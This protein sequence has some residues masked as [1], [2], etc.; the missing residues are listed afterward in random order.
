MLVAEKDIVG[1][2]QAAPD[3]LCTVAVG[4]EDP[5]LRNSESR[6]MGN[7]LN[8]TI[9]EKVFAVRIIYSL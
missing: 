6:N 8:K 4:L 5:E 9:S 1:R 2:A 3:T 7:S